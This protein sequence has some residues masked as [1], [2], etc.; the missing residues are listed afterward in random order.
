LCCGRRWILP[1]PP[2]HDAQPEDRSRDTS[3]SSHGRSRLKIR[4]NFA[5]QPT[6]RLRAWIRLQLELDLPVGHRMQAGY[7]ATVC[8]LPSP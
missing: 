1:A 3:L 4:R 2:H 8:G 7:R 6:H 5:L